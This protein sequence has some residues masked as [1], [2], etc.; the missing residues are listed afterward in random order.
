MRN[1]ERKLFRQPYYWVADLIYDALKSDV[2]LVMIANPATEEIE[3]TVV[4][5]NV[6]HM[7]AE[8]FDDE[9]VSEPYWPHLLG[10]MDVAEAEGTRYPITTDTAEITFITPAEPLIQWVDP[11]KPF[12]QWQEERVNIDS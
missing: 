2:R 7:E 9:P 12:Q 11:S 10:I 6:K 4:F 1:F 8:S 3:G 5:S